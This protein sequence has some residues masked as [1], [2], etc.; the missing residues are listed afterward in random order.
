MSLTIHNEVA[1]I[2]TDISLAYFQKGYFQ[3]QTYNQFIG[4]SNDD[5][6]IPFDITSEMAISIPRSPFGSVIRRNAELKDLQPFIADVFS[7]LESN[8]VRK[9]E[10]H[11]PSGIYKEFVES[12]NLEKTGF[13]TA[14]T[15]INQ[16]I[17]ISADWESSI[18]QMQK[19]KLNSLRTDGFQF[20]EMKKEEF[21]TAH[22]FLTVCRQAQG[23]QINIS[24]D[25][26]K[27]LTEQ[28]P[29]S[30]RCFGVFRDDK[31]SALCITVEVSEDI[32]YYYL[33]ATSPMFRDKSPMVLL[34]AGMVDFFH[35]KGFKYLDL[36]V[37]SLYGKSQEPLR[38]FKERMGAVETQ[39]PTFLRSH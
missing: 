24:W 3:T 39:K 34:I 23:L 38:I 19:R 27:N 18:H 22:K 1:S 25:H 9:I 6:F 5:F 30:Y 29:H 32:A 7:Q 13:E 10:I 2:P 26:L 31:I 14:Y 36:G 8:G 33:P 16:H 37:S 20:R 35:K 11:H 15:D 28:L 21:E 12:T 17:E 4:Y